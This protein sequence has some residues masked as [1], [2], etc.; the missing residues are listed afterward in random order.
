MQEKKKYN[1]KE[2]HLEGS[3]NNTPNQEAID[4]VKDDF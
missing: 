4:E 2:H 1:G 3:I